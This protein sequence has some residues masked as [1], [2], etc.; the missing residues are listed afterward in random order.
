MMNAPSASLKVFL[1]ATTVLY[2]RT[3]K[4]AVEKLTL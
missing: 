4:L 3:A 1:R 2:S